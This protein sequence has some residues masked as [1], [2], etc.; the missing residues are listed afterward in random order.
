MLCYATWKI[1]SHGKKTTVSRSASS[2][3]WSDSSLADLKQTESDHN[4]DSN[5]TGND[6][7]PPAIDAEVMPSAES[8]LPLQRSAHWRWSPPLYH[9]CD[10]EIRG[11][12][13]KV[14]ENVSST[15]EKWQNKV[16]TKVRD[17]TEWRSMIMRVMEQEANVVEKFTL[18]DFISTKLLH[19]QMNRYLKPYNCV[20]II[21][22]R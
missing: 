11:S 3:T 5:D 14:H 22:K 17:M 10:H 9:L 21:S 12:V 4:K 2:G 19:K 6:T 16:L 18:K 15:K 20:H 1:F 7:D 8:P 13:V